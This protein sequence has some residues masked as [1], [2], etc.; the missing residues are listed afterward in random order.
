MLSGSGT[1][2]SVV[3]ESIVVVV[4]RATRMKVVVVRNVLRTGLGVGILVVVRSGSTEAGTDV[5][6]R[7]ESDY[8]EA[9]R[10]T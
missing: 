4:Q 2:W 1:W 5:G 10:L 9:I 8:W 6:L 7:H 3:E